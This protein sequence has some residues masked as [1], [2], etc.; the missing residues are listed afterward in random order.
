MKG[1]WRSLREGAQAVRNL[2]K[3]GITS[4]SADSRMPV[5]PLAAPRLSAAVSVCGKRPAFTVEAALTRLS[6]VLG[7]LRPRVDHRAAGLPCPNIRPFPK[8]SLMNEQTPNP[9]SGPLALRKTVTFEQAEGV[10][11]LPR[12]LRLKELSKELRAKL[13]FVIHENFDGHAYRSSDA[14]Q[15]QQSRG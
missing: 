3:M 4:L 8:L 12:Q 9:P 2:D 6:L 11:P 10:E 13:W 7:S 1:P 5:K 14:G 15:R